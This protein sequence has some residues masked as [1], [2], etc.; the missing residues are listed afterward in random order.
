MALQPERFRMEMPAPRVLL[1]WRR[2]GPY[3][4]ARAQAAAKRF[5]LVGLEIS[6][7]DRIN[8]WAPIE[9]AV[10]F[11]KLTLCP[12]DDV[13]SLSTE[14]L[15]ARVESLLSREAP[16]VIVVHGYATRDALVLLEWACRHGRPAILMSD[17]NA[18]NGKR[19][20]W[21]EWVKSR[22]VGRLFAAGLAGGTSS[23]DYLI[24]LG[25]SPE[26]VFT[27]CDVVDNAHFAGTGSV[28]APLSVSMPGRFFFTSARF[29]QEKNLFRLLDAYALYRQK[30]GAAA[31]LF[32]I[33]GD[34][35]LRPELVVHRARLGL[36]TSALFAGYKHYD[37]LP[38][39]YGA[40]SCFILPSVNETWGLVV[41]EAMAAGLPVLVSNRCGC[42]RDL[43]REGANGFI[44]DPYNPGELAGL[45]F[46]LAHGG[47]NLEAMSI[48]SREIISKWAP[49][50][51]TDGLQQAVAAA[52]SAPRRKFTWLDKALLWGLI[53]L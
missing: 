40:A 20:R 19:R 28:T 17:T 52:L 27:G 9:G 48:I 35:P 34:G 30:A 25:L 31:W 45:M 38:N 41:N 10:G 3:H 51:F 7:I 46:R 5:S 24:D 1:A 11:E 36:E 16:S 33:V 39:W 53:H 14:E 49:D 47:L 43:V 29:I 26:H 8:G 50:R 13:D 2:F 6:S 21:K 12:V 44:F 23:R 32:A 18:F 37:E 42:A 4:H 22:I 15:A